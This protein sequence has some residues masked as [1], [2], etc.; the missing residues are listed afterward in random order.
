MRTAFAVE[1]AVAHLQHD[2]F[3][4]GQ[5]LPDERADAREG[6]AAVDLV[7]NG[8]R[9]GAEHFHERNFVALGIRAD[10]FFKG[11]VVAALVRRAQTH[12]DFV[13]NAAAGVGGKR[14][15]A[16]G[17]ER[18]DG[19]DQPDC[20]DGNQIVGVAAGHGVFARDVRH[21]PQVML[22]Q[23]AARGI[24]AFLHA[25]QARALLPSGKRLGK[26]R[27]VVEVAEKKQRVPDERR[28]KPCEHTIPSGG[29]LCAQRGK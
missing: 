16:V 1:K 9:I 7:R 22:D 19:L 13:F 17:T 10:R 25:A 27:A 28:E 26:R 11:N 6:D 3:A 21:Q 5:L 4:L 8:V 23:R 20:A 29:S 18:V 14:G 24:V 12:E 2:P 15:A